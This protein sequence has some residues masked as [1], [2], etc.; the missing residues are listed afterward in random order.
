MSPA[1]PSPI[2]ISATPPAA[3][4]RLLPKLSV[5][6]EAPGARVPAMAAAPLTV[7]VPPRVPLGVTV[8][9][10]PEASEPSTRR[11]PLLTVVAPV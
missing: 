9:A 2:S 4:V 6:M 7:P 10:L 8:T 5:P 11:T 3:K 1:G